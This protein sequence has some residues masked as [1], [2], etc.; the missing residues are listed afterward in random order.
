QLFMKHFHPLAAIT[1][2]NPD[3]VTRIMV[4]VDPSSGVIRSW[5]IVEGSGVPAY[6]A[7]AERARAARQQI[8]L[9]PEAHPGL[10]EPGSGVRR[11]AGRGGGE[12]DPA[13]H[14]G[15][16]RPRGEGLPRQ[17]PGAVTAGR[18]RP[19]RLDPGRR[20]VYGGTCCA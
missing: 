1:Q 13:A 2:S 7:A 18:R 15:V 5:E 4:R 16:P 14:R 11:P 6:D 20:T 17:R 19:A 9:P 8:P 12:A 3:L 10:A